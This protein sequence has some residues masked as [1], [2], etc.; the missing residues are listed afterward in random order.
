MNSD[1]FGE[2]EM[3]NGNTDF[4]QRKA[5]IVAGGS[6][7][8]VAIVAGFATFF[9]L[10]TLFVPGDAAATTNNIKA[11]EM[12]FRTGLL[13]WLIILIC[14]VLAA[15]GL[16]VFFKQVNKSVSLLTAWLRLVY[17]AIL[18]VAL[19][20]F[21]IVLL[22]IS[23]A[24]Y[25]RAFETDQLDTQVLLFLNAFYGLWD[26]G[27]VVFGFH[28]LGLSYLVFKSGYVPK[29]LGIL[30]ILAFVGYL[31]TSGANLLLP[32]YENYKATIKLVF[33]V[34]MVFGEFGLA[35]WLLFRG[36]KGSPV[37]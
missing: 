15:W 19:L 3:T 21:V 31:I 33:L 18:G 23:G 2:T 13:G 20:N 1:K 22:L 11:S 7:L 8:I 37:K 26:I 27:L 28:L 36:G 32:N 17:T 5:A 25:L 4:S 24:D 34:P 30:L 9:V 16:Y 29:I 14:D 35:L 10:D 12:L 6:I